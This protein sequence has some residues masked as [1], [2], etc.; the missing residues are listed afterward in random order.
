MS[1]WTSKTAS[2]DWPSGVSCVF[3]T[4][5]AV[6]ASTCHNVSTFAG[7]GFPVFGSACTHM[8]QRHVSTPLARFLVSRL[9]LPPTFS[10]WNIWMTRVPRR[11]MYPR[12]YICERRLSYMNTGGQQG[13]WHEVAEDH[14]HTYPRADANV[15]A[16]PTIWQ[17]AHGL[18]V[19]SGCTR[20]LSGLR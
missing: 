8:D 6:F 7:I 14:A 9:G 10:C 19:A 12:L 13:R 2:S 4:G 5:A 18:T 20:T 11:K 16:S 3:R 17:V 15:S 1:S